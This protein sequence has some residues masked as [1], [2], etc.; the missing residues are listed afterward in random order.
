MSIKRDSI[1]VY[2]GEGWN[3]IRFIHIVGLYDDVVQL[4]CEE[5]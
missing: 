3:E 1:T 4:L 5:K 2:C